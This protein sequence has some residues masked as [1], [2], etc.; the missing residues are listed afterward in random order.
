MK[1]TRCYNAGT[2][3]TLAAIALAAGGAPSDA[4]VG[5]AIGG[6][7]RAQRS[8]LQSFRYDEAV[9]DELGLDYLDKAGITSAGLEQLMRRLASQRV[10]PKS[11]QSQYYQT[12]PDVTQ[13][14]STFQDHTEQ[15]KHRT[16][17]IAEDKRQLMER[18][19]NKLR[20][21][22][23]PA[24][25]VLQFKGDRDSANTR[26]RHAIAHY[27]RGEL[28]LA[29]KLMYALSKAMPEDPFYHEF[30]G[31]IFYQWQIQMPLPA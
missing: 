28:A 21:Y 1:L 26:Y 31:D 7:D 3:T 27:R 19:V 8:M 25:T 29:H 20:A 10:L 9:A 17:P 14:L 13:R 18:I 6:T 30:R 24:Q 15:T 11:R 2:L 23:E 12:H 22:S 16:A 5:V 4:V